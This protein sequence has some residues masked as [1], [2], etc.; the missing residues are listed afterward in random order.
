MLV[1]GS[2][3]TSL[4]L[5]SHPRSRGE[6][7]GSERSE[8]ERNEPREMGCEGKD[9]RP[10]FLM[11][12]ASRRSW[13][14]RSPFVTLHL[15]RPEASFGSSET[16]KWWESSERDTRPVNEGRVD[17]AEG[18]RNGE[19][20]EGRADLF[21]V[22]LSPSGLRSPVMLGFLSLNLTILSSFT[23][24]S[25][26]VPVSV[27]SVHSSL[28]SLITFSSSHLRLITRVIRSGS[29]RKGTEHGSNERRA[30][31]T[32]FL[33]PLIWSASVTS[34]T[35]LHLVMSLPPNLVP[36]RYTSVDSVYRSLP[37]SVRFALRSFHPS[38]SPPARS[39]R[40]GW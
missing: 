9:I 7:S 28:P 23:S 10:E 35:A 37:S 6:R 40:A 8:K 3:V 19:G 14:V 24:D 13:S 31:Q 30:V 16:G 5:H 11:A 21:P 34:W 18:D 17:G 4:T 39:L 36:A 2:L 29:E 32:P 27:I 38:S 33:T 12:S 1:P 15:P 20:T 25:F 26:L 22:H